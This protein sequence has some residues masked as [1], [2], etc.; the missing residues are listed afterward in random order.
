M[1]RTKK[2]SITH[3][4]SALEVVKR[5]DGTF[6]LFL[7]GKLHRSEVAERWLPEV[8]CIRFGFC[9]Q[10]YD[11]ILFEVNQHGRKTLTFR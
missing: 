10:E 1:G 7:D 5:D 4:N 8:L 6:D 2:D 11:M 3:T 9:G